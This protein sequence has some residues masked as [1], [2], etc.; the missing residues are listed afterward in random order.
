MFQEFL[1]I[2]SQTLPKLEF[3]DYPGILT[4]VKFVIKTNHHNKRG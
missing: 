2:L 3:I 4:P 1:K